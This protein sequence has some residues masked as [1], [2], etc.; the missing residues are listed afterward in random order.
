MAG[1]VEAVL[2]ALNGAGVRYL[3]VGG[4][5]VILHGHLRTTAGLDLVVDLE[6]ENVLRAVNTLVSMGFQAR[7]PV[8]V[9]QFADESSRRD[10]VENKNMTVF[11]LWNQKMP[12][13]EVDIFVEAPFDFAEARAIRAPLDTTE[14][15]VVAI[16]DLI[17][18][19][20]AAGRPPGH[21]RHC[22]ARGAEQ[23]AGSW[24]VDE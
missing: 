10:W 4:V 20:R 13:F 5:A 17:A 7:A 24:G 14:A 1:N 15:P 19:K 2:A 12:G 21:G 11:S 3:I 22:G 9:A 6:S 18:L 8:A 23:C 16:A